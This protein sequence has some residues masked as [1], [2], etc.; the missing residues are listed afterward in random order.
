MRCPRCGAKLELSLITLDRAQEERE[1]H[2]RADRWQLVNQE[3]LLREIEHG[4]HDG[5]NGA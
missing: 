5:D 4:Q 1:A 3:A 2:D